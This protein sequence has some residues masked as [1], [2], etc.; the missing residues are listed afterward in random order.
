MGPPSEVKILA[1][2]ETVQKSHLACIFNTWNLLDHFIQNYY[3]TNEIVLLFETVYNTAI[4]YLKEKMELG[5]TG[6]GSTQP[7]P[8]YYQ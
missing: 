2:R 4:I 7:I 1:K 5:I 3:A 8:I 6:S